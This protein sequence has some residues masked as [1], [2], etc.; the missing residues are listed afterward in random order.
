M[1]VV[2]NERENLRI[3]VDESGNNIVAES[4]FVIEPYDKGFSSEKTSLLLV[5]PEIKRIYDTALAKIDD[6][7]NE[8][9]R[10]L[11][12]LSGLTGRTITPEKELMN[13]F[14]TRSIFEIIE[15]IPGYTS[16]IPIEKLGSIVYS[17]LFNE[18]TLPFLRNTEMQKQITEYIEK[19]DELITKSPIL[20]RK[21][22]HVQ[23]QA[24]HRNLV[25]SGF[26][27]AQ[28]SVSLYNGMKRDEFASSEELEN[29][30][31]SEKKKIFSD[32][33]LEKKFDVIDKK[34]SNA[35]L[36]ALRDCLNENREIL[37]E[38]GNIDS[39]QKNLLI[40]YF[41]KLHI[42]TQELRNVYKENKEVINNAIEQ[43]KN[44]RTQW[45]QVVELFKRRFCVP[46]NVTIENQEDV[47]LKE[48]SPRLNFVF[49]D[50]MESK[51]VDRDSL[52]EILSQG[53]KR[54]LY[55]MNILFELNARIKQNTQ[56]ILIVDDIAD[57]FDYKN[58]YAIVEYFREIS[59]SPLFSTIFLTHNFDFHR[60]ISSRFCIQRAYRYFVN[61]NDGHLRL[62]Q[63]HY[64]NNPFE[65]WKNQLNIPRYLIS[66][67]PFV[68]NL[69]EYCGYLDVE[70][71]L[72]STLHLKKNTEKIKISDI[73]K[74]F[75]EVLKDKPNL[76]IQNKDE[77]YVMVLITSANEIFAESNETTELES[78]II[79]S[80]AIRYLAEKYMIG[81][82]NNERFVSHISKNQTITLFKE[83]SRLF[84][85]RKEEIKLLDEVNI[86]TPENI[87]LNS[88]MY[89]PLI[90]MSP[91]N[92]KTLYKNIM[93]LD[94]CADVLSTG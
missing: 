84:P 26:F 83:Y 43:A 37:I 85:S 44:E 23:A 67:I 7:K 58:K 94:I 87:H 64:Q 52:L 24:I 41:M 8:F 25:D 38:L 62:Q 33:N 29:K 81:K 39:L 72:T 2:F 90:D 21:F 80:I 88:F 48:S 36:R 3:I 49:V 17:I 15:N 40:A 4:I 22:N 1:D 89:E 16:E 42:I 82:I 74:A 35:E 30:I 46:F 11:K 73:E 19:Y 5:N 55:I 59:S 28:H 53:E 32:K 54:A 6:K 76:N 27:E 10:E 79:L 65:I 78:K 45:E 77:Y 51:Q 12:Q 93:E 75:K 66:S 50:D 68:R 61:R 9:I 13:I 91:V 34:L 92:L 63:E 69:A 86:M 47:I 70:E 14:K 60:T 18:K 57:S 71:Q 20:N 31:I 56:T